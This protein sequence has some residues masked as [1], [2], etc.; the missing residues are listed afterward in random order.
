MLNQLRQNERATV[1]AILGDDSVD[2]LERLKMARREMDR[3]IRNERREQQRQPI[4][5]HVHPVINMPDIVM[6][7]M[8]DIVMPEIKIPPAPPMPRIVIPPTV[9]NIEKPDPVVV[10]VPPPAPPTP[11]DIKPVR[12]ENGTVISYRR[13]M[14]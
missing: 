14:R 3:A 9:V 1:Q 12:D 10:N 8:P 2:R 4:V 7:Q 11:Y 13:V 6:P 5:V